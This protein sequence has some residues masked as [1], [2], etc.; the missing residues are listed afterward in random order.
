MEQSLKSLKLSVDETESKE[1]ISEINDE[2]ECIQQI[3]KLK[4]QILTKNKK[5]SK[6]NKL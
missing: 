4:E 6:Q 2:K 1:V 5:R 3:E